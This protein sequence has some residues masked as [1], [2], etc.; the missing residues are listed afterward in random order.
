MPF[1]GK[2]GAVEIIL[3]IGIVLLIFGP[4]KLPGLSRAL[5]QGIKNFKSALSGKDEEQEEEPKK[6]EAENESSS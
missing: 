1:I 6:E 2:I 3:I 5:G 4:G